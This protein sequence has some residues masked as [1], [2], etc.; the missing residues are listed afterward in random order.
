[1]TIIIMMSKYKY[2]SYYLYKR[3]D[4]YSNAC[5]T[6]KILLKILVTIVPTKISFSKLKFYLKSIVSQKIK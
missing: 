2:N 3:L 4:F 6:Y 1:M 5:I